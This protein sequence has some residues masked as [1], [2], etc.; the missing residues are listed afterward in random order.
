ME[1]NM[2]LI[3]EQK[4]ADRLARTQA[5][6]DRGNKRQEIVNER[7]GRVSKV[8]NEIHKLIADNH[9]N[10]RI[11]KQVLDEVAQRVERCSYITITENDLEDIRVLL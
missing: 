5:I 3:E 10:V 4:D 9:L 8:T 11:A 1:Q 2:E 7:V 6:I